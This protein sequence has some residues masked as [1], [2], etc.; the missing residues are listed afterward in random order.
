MAYEYLGASDEALEVN[1]P[2]EENMTPYEQVRNV[3]EFPFDL[4]PYQVDYVNG[5][6]PD[7][8]AGFYWE[9]G[10]GKTA[11]STHWA[12]FRSMCGAAEQWIV[13]V[14][15][16]LLAQWA[17]WIQSIKYK[18]GSGN[19]TATIYRG[20][21]KQRA[22]I[23]LDADF[24]VMSYV[25]F[26]NDY[27]YLYESLE[28]K[29]VGII[30]DEGHAVKNIKSQNNKAVK[31]WAQGRPLAIL[32]GTPLT[33]LDDAYAY[34]KFLA[35]TVYRNKNHFD[36]LHIAATDDYGTPTAWQN[37]DLLEQNMRINSS[38]VIR[39]EVQDQLPGITYTPIVY[40]LDPA[41]AKLYKRIAE[42]RL[43]EFDNG[44]EIDAISVQALYSA[45]QQIVLNW[46]EFA[47]DPDLRPAALDLVEEVL[48]ELGPEGK[49][50]VVAN[51]IRSNRYLLRELQPYGAVA[52]YGEVS[53]AGKQAAIERFM[54]DPTCRVIILQP[55]SAGF[56]VDGLQ[57]VCSDMLFLEAPTVA[58]PFHQTV[59]R[60]DRDGQKDP[61]NCRVAMAS[62]TVQVRMFKNLLENDATINAVQGGYQDLKEAIFG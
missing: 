14:P 45:L 35:P 15:P 48:S 4:R 59:A 40:D 50:V 10:S 6:C 57:H 39:R 31:H 26:K 33:K 56:G 21:P 54:K 41:H 53:A 12:L 19:L 27:E 61:V 16:I 5:H 25:I 9:A 43:V 28:G 30:A 60:L 29:S 13:L 62:K 24:I 58:P 23:K 8:N 46:G 7:D 32:T 34:V 42:E 1:T 47:D 17:R 3:F 44:K 37:L 22:E 55:Q 38:R 36:R 51:F 18:D 11:G 20:S 2:S 49:L 52:V